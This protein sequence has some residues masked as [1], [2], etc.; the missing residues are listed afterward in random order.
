MSLL[1]FTCRPILHT[2]SANVGQGTTTALKTASH[3]GV[4]RH[5][6]A[7]RKTYQ[8]CTDA[9][10][11]ILRAQRK[12]RP[13]SPHLTIYQPQLTWYMSSAHRITGC[14]MGGA[15]YLGA[16]AYLA[17]P[18]FGYHSFDANTIVSSFGAA[19]EAV[20]ISAKAI[21]ALPFT[22]HASNGIR[23]L[24]WDAGKCL[25][26]KGVYNTGYVVLASTVLG[27]AYLATM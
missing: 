20:K 5:F 24:I 23:H 15:L 9:E 7:S 11:D 4:V 26:I 27:T 17:A 1:T 18:A 2:L 12:L 14:A 3:L 19:P 16:M 10:T 6:Q 21:L 25:D 13:S 8:Q 22:F